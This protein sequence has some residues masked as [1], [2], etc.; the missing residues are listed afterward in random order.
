MQ[1]PN[2]KKYNKN[3]NITT[4]YYSIRTPPRTI[5]LNISLSP[6]RLL[7]IRVLCTGFLELPRVFATV[8]ILI[9][10]IIENIQIHSRVL[11]LVQ[12]MGGARNIIGLNGVEDLI[13]G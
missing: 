6:P 8:H 7:H 13:I 2:K 11:M 1:N 10:S 5:N 3:K 12:S 9:G 4:H